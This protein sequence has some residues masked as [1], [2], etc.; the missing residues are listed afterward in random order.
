MWCNNGRD[1]YSIGQGSEW[2]KVVDLMK[3]KHTPY[4]KGNDQYANILKLE[5]GLENVYDI[6]EI[7]LPKMNKGWLTCRVHF[8]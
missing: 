6:E 7:A 8:L 5:T 1:W 2:E 4:H 3:D